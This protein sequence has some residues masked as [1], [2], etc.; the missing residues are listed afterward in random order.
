MRGTEGG[1]AL[2]Q[3]AG[4]PALAETGRRQLLVTP[5]RALYFS[6]GNTGRVPSVSAAA[7]SLPASSDVQS[8][9][10][11]V[12]LGRDRESPTGAAA[13][14]CASQ[15]LNPDGGPADAAANLERYAFVLVSSRAGG[16]FWVTCPEAAQTHLSEHAWRE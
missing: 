2:N 9:S 8:P 6:G 11:K 12:R 4:S 10:G 16:G 13:D 7:G 15:R 1:A 5:P 3:P 14:S